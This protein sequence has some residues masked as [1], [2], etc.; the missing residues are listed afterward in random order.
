MSKSKQENAI[1]LARMILDGHWKHDDSEGTDCTEP[2]EDGGT[3]S[4]SCDIDRLVQL[5]ET[6][7]K[8]QGG[9]EKARPLVIEVPITDEFLRGLAENFPEAAQY[10]LRCLS[11]N[12]EKFLFEF[13][14][15]EE[16]KEHTLDI[17][18]ARRGFEIFAALRI[19][20]KLPGL[21]LG[22]AWMTD[23]GAWDAYA[24]DAWLQCCLLG[25]VV[26]G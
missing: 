20:G 8:E 24:I 22:D 12:Y 19:G 15:E 18:K 13:L 11:F 21:D 3:Q 23:G 26:Y 14:D 25:E 7:H 6:V 9:E 5:A 16:N 2:A 17:E 1:E 10:S 4:E